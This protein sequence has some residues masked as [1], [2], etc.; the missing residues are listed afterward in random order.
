MAKQTYNHVAM[1]DFEIKTQEFIS[2]TFDLCEQ[3]LR[4]LRPQQG[5]APDSRRRALQFSA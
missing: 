2:L 4:L 5:Q 3:E 1:A